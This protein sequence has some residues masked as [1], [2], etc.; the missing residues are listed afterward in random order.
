MN[1][2]AGLSKSRDFYLF[3]NILLP[4]SSAVISYSLLPVIPGNHQSLSMGL[5][6]LD[7]PC[8]QNVAEHSLLCLMFF[9]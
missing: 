4:L 8:E 2:A 7:I 6:I 1:L 9:T 5:S 3:Q